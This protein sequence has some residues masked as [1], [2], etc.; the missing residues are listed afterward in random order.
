MSWFYLGKEIVTP[1]EGAVGFVYI[2][3]NKATGKKYVGKKLFWFTKTLPPL[4]GAKRKRRRIVE[5][6]W[7]TYSGSN[8]ETKTIGPD[9]FHREILHLCATKSAMSYLET[10]EIILRDALLRDDFYNGL[11]DVKVGSRGLKQLT[12][13]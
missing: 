4:K 9:A 10:R 6:N 12:C 11:I 2:L 1:P 8:P 13:E 5:S 7:R 3:T